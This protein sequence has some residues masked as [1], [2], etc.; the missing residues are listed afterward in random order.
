MKIEVLVATMFQKDF[1]KYNEMNIQTD[2]LFVNQD[3]RYAYQEGIINGKKMRMFT[4]PE[5]GLSRSRNTALLRASGD[6]CLLSD[7]DVRYDDDYA[8][9][10]CEAFGR[11]PIADIIVFNT[12]II[13]SSQ[14]IVRKSFD[15]IKKAPKYRSYGSVR[16]AFKLSS[17]RKNNIWFNV[18]FGAGSVFSAGEDSLFLR[19]AKRLGLKIFEYPANI[20]SVDYSTST[21]F[22]G[23]NEKYFYDKGA[24]LAASYK[25]EKHFFKYYFLLRMAKHSKLSK[26]DIVGLMNDGITGYDNFLP[27]E[28]YAS[29]LNKQQRN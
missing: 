17:I 6:I 12:T 15:K 24:F 22:N 28:E 23:Y 7:D 2:A 10:V 9:I 27:Y 16:I 11:I 5:R 20:A 21:W 13:N 8:S 14:P 4:T 26:R 29:Q 3:D 1:S 18:N 19:D 25:Y